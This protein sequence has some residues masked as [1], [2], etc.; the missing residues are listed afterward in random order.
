[1]GGSSS[2]I[3]AVD[4]SPSVDGYLAGR[5][6][7]AER[8]FGDAGRRL[9]QWLGM[10]GGNPSEADEEIAGRMLAT[11]GAVVIGRRLF[12]VGIGEWGDDGAWGMPCF[13][14]TSRPREPL[15]KGPTTFTFVTEGVS[16]A[17]KF[18]RQTAAGRD[19]VIAGGGDVVSQC[20]AAGLVDEFRLHVVPV[21]LGAG[22]PL[23]GE[24]MP[25]R[26]ELEQTGSVTT[27]NAT[28]LT[29]R[30]RRA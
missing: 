13:V 22:T 26:V 6:V 23:F 15:V 14:V 16:H 28:H 1:M 18:A 25:E 21:L 29:Y 4:V 9:H 5:G 17:V 30:V 11:A 12:D 19:V 10:E 2:G 7:S 3:V 20:L 8:P 24:S 27:P